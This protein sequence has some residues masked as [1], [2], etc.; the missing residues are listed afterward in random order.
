M[1]EQESDLAVKLRLEMMTDIAMEVG[2]ERFMAA[3][4]QAI[5]LSRH[6]YDCSIARI[7][8]CAGLHQGSV[9]SPAMKAWADVTEI[10]EKHV[11]R[12]PEGGWRLEDHYEQRGGVWWTTP[13]PTIS[14]AMLRAVKMIGGWA[15][16]A[17][18]DPAYWNQ[19]M[20]DFCAAYQE[21]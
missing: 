15:A 20:R 19:R 6:R 8:E 13:V 16:L 4:K 7:R 21:D 3:V 1:R 2:A 9:M 14:P 10:V 11:R 18:T 17:Q 12:S 5:T